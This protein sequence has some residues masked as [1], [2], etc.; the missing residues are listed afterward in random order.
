MITV[1]SI[2]DLNLTIVN[3]LHLI[4]KLDIDLIVGIPRSGM[5]VASLLATHLQK[6]MTDIDDYLLGYAF[7]KSGNQ[8]DITAQ[9]MN[10]LLVDDTINIGTQMK[11]IVDR[12]ST[13]SYDHNI[14]KFVVYKS[15]KTPNNAIDVF[16][17]TCPNPRAFQWNLWKHPSLSKW[18]TDLDGVLCRDPIWK[19]ENDRGPK[20]IEF[21]KT[22]DKKFHL[23]H[24]I[25]YIIT[26]RLDRHRMITEEWLSKNNIK[27]GTL[28]MKPESSTLD[29]YEFKVEALKSLS[30]VELY[31]ES[32]VKQAKL[33]SSKIS[34]PVWCV[35]SQTTYY[36]PNE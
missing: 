8:I 4:T 14:I 27:Y 22:A 34:I 13:I 28:I 12:L 10:V 19:V 36:P 2:Y 20:L 35:D 29:H 25:K 18:A 6:P 32:D 21:Y 16:L 5:L 15:N 1:K 24:P 11:K 3:N 17:E 26:S 31:I 30:D 23:S 33:I 7:E 9:K